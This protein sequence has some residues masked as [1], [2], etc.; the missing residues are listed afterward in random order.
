MNRKTAYMIAALLL[1]AVTAAVVPQAAFGA[2]A[3]VVITNTA[4]V[5]YNVS[6]IAQT[7]V[8]GSISFVVDRRINMTVTNLAN[9][10]SAPSATYQAVQ[11]LV[12]NTSNTTIR[13]ELQAISRGTNT[14]TLTGANIYRDNNNNGL[15]DAGD[16]LYGNAGTFGDIAT[17][18]SI[19][20]LIVGDIPASLPNGAAAIY[21]LLATAVDAGTTTV[22]GETSGAGTMGA[23]DT[24]F[25]DGA[26]SI[27]GARS[28]SYSAA[29]TF[30]ISTATI[31][32]TKAA[33]VYSDPS[34]GTTNPKAIPGAFVTYTVTISN[35]AGAAASNVTVTDN[36]NAEITAN[37]I[38]FR[39]TL[40]NGGSPTCAA[41]QGSAYS[42]DGGATWTCQSGT[43]NAGTNTLT[44]TI[45][46][47]IAAGGSAMIRYQVRVE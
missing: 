21:D 9:V 7:A 27:D 2:D 10:T 30:T 28:G 8:T 26:G 19:T 4:T 24:V 39:T 22:S 33:A 13:F 14:W 47:T 32:V 34:N 40:D 1:V 20:V 5:N 11:F 25:V 43:W 23:V 15:W 12:T 17:G 6:G 38:T 29:G 16:Q 35:S 3:G 42:T 46:G 31:A 36:L 44:S 45:P 41:G 37:H 18:G